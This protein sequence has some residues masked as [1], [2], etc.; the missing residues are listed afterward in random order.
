MKKRN[1]VDYWALFQLVYDLFVLTHG[2]SPFWDQN[3]LAAYHDF[4][5]NPKGKKMKDGV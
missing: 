4:L 3:D 5:W 2:F 1:D